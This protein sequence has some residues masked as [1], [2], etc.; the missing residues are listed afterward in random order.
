MRFVNV[1][2]TDVAALLQL[3]VFDGLDGLRLR[4]FDVEEESVGALE[5]PRRMEG[6]TSLLLCVV[7]PLQ[8]V[9]WKDSRAAR[10][11]LRMERRVRIC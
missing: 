5:N 1:A 9:L 8:D 4:E 3:N 2:V 6:S 7:F 10:R 11:L